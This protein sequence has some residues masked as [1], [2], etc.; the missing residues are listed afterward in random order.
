MPPNSLGWA[1]THAAQDVLRVAH[2]PPLRLAAERHPVPMPLPDDDARTAHR[3]TRASEVA[4]DFTG[5]LW[6]PG[7]D[8]APVSYGWLLRAEELTRRWT[9]QPVRLDLFRGA[10]DR[11]PT[12]VYRLH[13][14]A[15]GTDPTVLF[16]GVVT[17]APT[18]VL[19]D[20]DD[21]VRE[22]LKHVLGHA[23][24]LP[25][26]LTARQHHFLYQH[27]PNCSPPPPPP[28]PTTPT[29]PAPASPSAPPTATTGPPAPSWPPSTTPTAPAT[30]S[31]PTPPPC[32]AT[33]GAT[34]P[35][36]PCAPPAP[37]PPTPRPA[38]TPSSPNPR[39]S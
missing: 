15:P 22:A 5:V 14:T 9:H 25:D 13:E 2:A 24:L 6:L 10:L 38:P 35:P 32:P 33:P 8:P 36:G 4:G 21:A 34:T 27:T 17:D 23:L 20:S 30:C 3:P 39:A 26:T 12:I 31:D 37:T 18:T 7:G 19:A 16:S 28:R 29:H 11:R 1:I